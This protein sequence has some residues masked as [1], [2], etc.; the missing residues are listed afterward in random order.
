MD[1]CF[2]RYSSHALFAESYYMYHGK[3]NITVHIHDYNI[4]QNFLVQYDYYN[5]LSFVAH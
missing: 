1:L 4:L 2:T 3:I 5:T